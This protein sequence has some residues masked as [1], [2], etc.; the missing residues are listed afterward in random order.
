MNTKIK[1]PF[2]FTLRILL[3]AGGDLTKSGFI[4]AG[5]AI[6]SKT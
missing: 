1:K 4:A 2:F 3:A 5:M 6:G